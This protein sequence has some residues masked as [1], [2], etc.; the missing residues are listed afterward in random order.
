[1]R[2]HPLKV[3]KNFSFSTGGPAPQHNGRFFTASFGSQK[4]IASLALRLLPR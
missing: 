4:T 3:E 1:M 2:Q